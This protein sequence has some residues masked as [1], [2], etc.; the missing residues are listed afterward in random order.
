MV[1]SSAGAGSGDFH[2]YRAARRRELERQAYVL[3]MEQEVRGSG[4]RVRKRCG[5]RGRSRR[6]ACGAR[7]GARRLQRELKEQIE[8]TRQEREEKEAAKTAKKRK[9]RMRRKLAKKRKVANPDGS[10]A[11]GSGSDDSDAGDSG[12][13]A[14][15]AE[16]A[17]TNGAPAATD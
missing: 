16:A 7:L 14:G 6:R 17:A 3:E 1:G 10:N 9:E 15:G 8:R 11:G 2:V 12:D 4:A 13:E 5:P